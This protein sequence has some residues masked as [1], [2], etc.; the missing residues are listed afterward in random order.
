MAGI[1]FFS[2]FQR[3]AIPG[4]IFNELQTDLRLSAAGVTALGSV[5]LYIYAGMQLA[6][7]FSAD[8]FGGM[9]TLVF[10]GLLMGIGA[11][12]FPLSHSG[13]FA[14]ASRAL[15][16]FGA[17]FMYLCI[18]KELDHQFS[19]RRFAGMVGAVLCFGYV[20][21]LTAT[22]PFER[23]VAAFG[24]R[25]VLFV[26]GVLI[27]VCLGL[28]TWLMREH[29]RARPVESQFSLAP[30]LETVCNKRSLPLLISA[31]IIFPGYFVI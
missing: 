4:T 5:F 6:V 23:A 25:Q 13:A 14:Y 26:V 1:Y 12:L 31:F 16:G 24:W 3:A 21:G 7:G 30:L 27:L 28:A 2:F 22:L 20:G 18:I 11:T 19:P 29:L 9:R 8:R 17:S 10:G 15:T